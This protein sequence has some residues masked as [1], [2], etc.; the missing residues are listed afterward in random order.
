MIFS[1]PSDEAERIAT[2]HALC[3]LDTEPEREFDDLVAVAS[4]IM[5]CPTA[6]ISLLDENRQWYKARVGYDLPESSRKFAFCEYTIADA[7]RAL[8]VPDATQDLRFRENPLVTAPNGL[9]FYA[10]ASVVVDGVAVGTVCTL[11]TVPREV[12]PNQLR[13]LEAL[14]RQ[15]ASL[16]RTRALST[17]L[18][19]D[20]VLIG[21]AIEASLDAMMVLE[22]VDENGPILDYRFVYANSR[23]GTYFGTNP[24]RL[25]GRTVGEMAEPGYIERLLDAYNCVLKMGAPYEFEIVLDTPGIRGRWVRVQVVRAGRGIAVTKR[26]VHEQRIQADEL[27]KA[28]ERI[29]SKSRQLEAHQEALEEANARL[30][31][32]ATTDDLTGLLNSREFARRLDVEIERSRRTNEPLSIVLADVDHFKRVNDEHGHQAG[33]GVLRR[34]GEALRNSARTVDSIARYGGEEFVAILPAT[35]ASRARIVAERMREAIADSVVGDRR[36]TAS[37]GIATFG[38]GM[39][40][41]A[42]IRAADRA[43]YASKAAGRN[44]TTHIQDLEL[45]E[46][47]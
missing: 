5:E 10:G 19:E 46:A 35:E 4:A 21:S 12:R 17:R 28:Y 45:A 16:L 27:A 25:L 44:R 29:E 23:T 8:V 36:V 42:A 15:A 26:D 24:G 3:V 6:L 33:D 20:E 1:S 39:N 14:A 41:D 40:S 37:F 34:V 32:L 43:L 47:A 38:A 7:A 18:A 22:P 30:Q 2:L 31:R 11:D 9:R 13:A